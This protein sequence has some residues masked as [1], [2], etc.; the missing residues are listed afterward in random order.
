MIEVIKR[1]PN[2]TTVTEAKFVAI[3][4]VKVQS[5]GFIVKI[6]DSLVSEM[7]YFE[8]GWGFYAS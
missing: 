5:D 3:K 6:N 7:L 8:H 2:T 4:V 1:K